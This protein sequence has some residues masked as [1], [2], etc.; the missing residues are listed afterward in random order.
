MNG[1]IFK[2]SN[3][4][5]D[6][7]RFTAKNF[8]YTCEKLPKLWEHSPLVK[9]TTTLTVKQKF[10]SYLKVLR[11]NFIIFDFQYIIEIG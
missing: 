9:Y 1:I 3:D 6:S 11:L 2:L 10:Q 8:P 5:Y 4:F 7:Y